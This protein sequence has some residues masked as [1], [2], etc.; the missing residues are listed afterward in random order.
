M[1]KVILVAID[2]RSTH[3]IGAFFRTADGFGSD[4]MLAGQ[5]TPR[6]KGSEHD[7]RLPHIREKA[8][9]A[10]HKTALGAEASVSWSYI[11][12]P[13]EAIE[14]LRNSGYHLCAI[15]QD[16]TSKPLSELP[17]DQAI[18]LIMGPEVTGLDTD[19]LSLCDDTYEIPMIGNKESFNVSVAAGIAL[20]QSSLL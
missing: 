19:I 20:Y 8:H 9:N 7:D 5:T 12:D 1:R 11:A 16:D 4:V 13:K 18:A 17:K 14:V 3:N 10:I 6:P 15:E 2:I